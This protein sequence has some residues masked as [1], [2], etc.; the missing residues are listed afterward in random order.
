MYLILIALEYYKEAIEQSPNISV[1]FAE[2]DLVGTG[3]PVIT[4]SKA[5]YINDQI[6]GVVSLQ[7]LFE[8]FNIMFEKVYTHIYIYIYIE[9]QAIRIY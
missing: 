3:G 8:D 5:L 2:T 6:I 7:F 9:I 4:V 1:Y